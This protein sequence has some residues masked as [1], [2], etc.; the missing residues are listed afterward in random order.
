MEW[1]TDPLLREEIVVARPALRALPMHYQWNRCV[2]A[3]L[4]TWKGQPVG[5]VF[6]D[7]RYWLRWRRREHA[8]TA[9]SAAQAQRFMA[10]WLRAR[11]HLAPLLDADL[12]PRTLVPL[13]DFLREYEGR[14]G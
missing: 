1:Q 2:G 10:R 12:P 6:P 5:R 3:W 13:A 4:L 11:R 14:A 7:G 8:G 9:A